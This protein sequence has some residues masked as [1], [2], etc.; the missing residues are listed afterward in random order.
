MTNSGGAG[1]REL[2]SAARARALGP[3]GPAARAD[4]GGSACAIAVVVST[5][6]ARSARKAGR[7][8]GVSP[9]IPLAG[10]R[11]GHPAVLTQSA[12]LTASAPETNSGDAVSS[13]EPM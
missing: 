12:L 11:P 6:S 13:Q 8:G 9:R 5:N 10:F 2:I 7:A 3:F 4:A 1:F